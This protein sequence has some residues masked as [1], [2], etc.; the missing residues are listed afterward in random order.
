MREVLDLEELPDKR[1]GCI[2]VVRTQQLDRAARELTAD[3]RDRRDTDD[4]VITKAVT[5]LAR[6]AMRTDNR[7]RDPQHLADAREARRNGLAHRG[8]RGTP[9]L[10]LTQ[11]AEPLEELFTIL[12]ILGNH[13]RWTDTSH[14]LRLERG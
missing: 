8:A 11:P 6:H 2:P 7:A 14:R 9:R 3:L 10:L 1:G 5:R 13:E 12:L 4:A